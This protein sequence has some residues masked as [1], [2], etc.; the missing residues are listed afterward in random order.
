MLVFDE[1]VLVLGAR[2]VG[3]D[4]QLQL[5]DVGLEHQPQEA[6]GIVR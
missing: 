1:N 6:V 3:V 5:S 2:H 4:V